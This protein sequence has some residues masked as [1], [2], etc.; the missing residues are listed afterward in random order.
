MYFLKFML[1]EGQDR[2]QDTNP[3]PMV[4][5]LDT[6]PIQDTNPKPMDHT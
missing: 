3:K 5:T 6:Y 1:S 4:P 2:V